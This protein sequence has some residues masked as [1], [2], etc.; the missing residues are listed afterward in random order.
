[1]RFASV[2]DLLFCLLGG[3]PVVSVLPSR[4]VCTLLVQNRPPDLGLTACFEGFRASWEGVFVRRGRFGDADFSGVRILLAYLD[5][6]FRLVVGVRLCFFYF[7]WLG[8]V[9]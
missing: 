4:D 1:M 2:P 5:L 8:C 9:P 6:R 3:R 7:A